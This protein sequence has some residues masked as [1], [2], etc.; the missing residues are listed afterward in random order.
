MP[1][2][3]PRPPVLPLPFR[4]EQPLPELVPGLSTY[5][6]RAMSDDDLRAVLRAVWGHGDFRGRQLEMLHAVLGGRSMLAVLPTGAGKSLCYQLPALLLP[7]AG[8]GVGPPVARA[9]REARLVAPEGEC[10]LQRSE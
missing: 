10:R 3:H 7:G 8:Q 1:A 9:N 2:P 5:D 6:P 4:A